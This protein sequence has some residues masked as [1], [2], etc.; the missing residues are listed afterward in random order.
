MYRPELPIVETLAQ[1]YEAWAK[2]PGAL[3]VWSVLCKGREDVD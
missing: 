3:E 1:T 2:T